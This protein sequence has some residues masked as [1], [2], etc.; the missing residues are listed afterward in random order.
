[1]HDLAHIL[2]RQR[3]FSDQTFGP[4]PRAKGVIDHIQK[5]IK[6]VEADPNSLEEWID[7]AILAF[8]GAGRQGYTARE[9]E[10]AY[11]EK[12]RRNAARTWPDWRTADP[13]KAI[14]H[15]RT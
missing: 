14:E 12:L 15:V 10:D 2:E 6:E 5:E 11:V 9:I 4:G 8:D 7:I 13:D 1:M 3:R